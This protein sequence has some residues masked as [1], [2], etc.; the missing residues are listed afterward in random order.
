VTRFPGQGRFDPD[1]LSE[2]E[3]LAQGRFAQMLE[4]YIESA[5]ELAAAL[6][7]ALAQKDR[8][9]A[10]RAAHALKSASGQA[11]V[12]TLRDMAAELERSV[13]TMPEEAFAAAVRKIRDELGEASAALR[14]L[15]ER[16]R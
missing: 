16:S 13:L 5:D 11:G 3:R 8:T 7:S 9:A 1:V 15:A 14:S 2:L 6:E 12:R 4:T 10:G